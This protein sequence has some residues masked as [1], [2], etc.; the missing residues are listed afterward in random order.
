VGVA[1]PRCLASL[2]V[3]LLLLDGSPAWAQ[4][5]VRPAAASDS[6]ELLRRAHHAQRDFERARRASLPVELGS[7]RHT[8]D[9]RIGRY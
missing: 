2:V 8:C 7:A 9:E 3:M 1:R 6:R 5:S 4:A